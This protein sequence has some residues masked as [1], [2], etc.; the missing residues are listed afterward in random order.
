MVGLC[1]GCR[2]KHGE[3]ECRQP[4][5]WVVDCAFFERE[6]PGPCGECKRGR[7]LDANADDNANADENADD[8]DVAAARESAKSADKHLN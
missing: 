7:W 3:C 2:K 8:S 5:T 4:G 1:A 6:T